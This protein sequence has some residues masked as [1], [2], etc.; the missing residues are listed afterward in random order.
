MRKN[1][2]L[3]LALACFLGLIAI[4]VFDGYLGIY[5]T[6]HL[7]IG[8][9]QEVIEP[10]YWL[11]QR[12]ATPYEYEI[13]YYLS[14][15][16][17]QSVLFRYEIDNRRFT[18]YDTL[19]QA[20]LWQENEKLFDLFSEEQ[21]IGSFDKATMEWT[22]LTEGLDEPDTSVSRFVQYTVRITYGEVERNIVVEFYYP[23]DLGPTPAK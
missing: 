10:D 5:D 22:L 1:L 12:P 14:A 8:E 13:D 7:T 9:R 21:S 11:D 4:F 3:Y 2:F 16:W 19:C 17:G 18:A 6:L 15:E 23:D 20:S